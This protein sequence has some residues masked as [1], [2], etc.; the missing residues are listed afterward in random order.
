MQNP[1]FFGDWTINSTGKVTEMIMAIFGPN[2]VT[3]YLDY[4]FN[5]LIIFSASFWYNKILI[6]LF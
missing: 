5:G 2:M 6:S 3:M 4:I 1:T